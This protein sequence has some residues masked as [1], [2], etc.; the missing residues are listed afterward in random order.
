MK[1]K[2][3]SVW[4]WLRLMRSSAFESVFAV[5]NR[6]PPCL[7]NYLLRYKIICSRR[8]MAVAFCRSIASN[9]DCR[10]KCWSSAC[11]GPQQWKGDLHTKWKHNHKAVWPFYSGRCS[12]GWSHNREGVETQNKGMGSTSHKP[13]MLTEWF[14]GKINHALGDITICGFRNGIPRRAP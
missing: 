7:S 9:A 5:L 12:P 1:Y 8:G 3:F 2:S 6:Y 10:Q 14:I 4:L 13:E 11:V